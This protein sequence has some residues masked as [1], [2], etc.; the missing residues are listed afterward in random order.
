MSEISN[1]GRYYNRVFEEKAIA[2]VVAGC[3]QGEVS[4]ALGVSAWSLGE[5]I[6]KARAGHVPDSGG[7]SPTDFRHGIAKSSCL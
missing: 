2:L 7:Q 4:R 5:W 6:K 1:F 3:S